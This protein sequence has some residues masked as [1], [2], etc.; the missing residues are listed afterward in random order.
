MIKD[1]E[2]PPD[3]IIVD[4]STGDVHCV[5]MTPD[6][7]AAQQAAAAQL[8]QQL[9]ADAAARQQQID[10]VTASNDP[11]LLALADLTGVVL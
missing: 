2:A 7:V 10:A 4:C 6:E 9:Q 3:N 1:G 11:A 8:A 5:P